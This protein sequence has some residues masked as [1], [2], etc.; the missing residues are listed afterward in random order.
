MS[1]TVIRANGAMVIPWLVWILK[2]LKLIT[3]NLDA[4]LENI[5]PKNTV[6]GAGSTLS[7]VVQ[8]DLVQ[9]A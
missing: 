4:F 5:D 9:T 7:T 6:S 8:N 3:P 1:V 2:I